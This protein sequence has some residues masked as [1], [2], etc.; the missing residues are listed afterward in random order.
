MPRVT[1]NAQTKRKSS[2]KKRRV[3]NT[4]RIKYGSTSA[5]SQKKQIMSN[6]V[7]IQRVKRMLPPPVW[8]DYQ[9]TG[10][11]QSLVIPGDDA[12]QLN[13]D[14]ISLMDPLNWTQVL[15]KDPTVLDKVSTKVL[16]I[17]LNLRYTLNFSER[18]QISLFVVTFRRNAANRNPA[19]LVDND[20]YIRDGQ[21]YNVR[22]N[23]AV[24]KVH[25]ARDVS[26]TSNAWE[27]PAAVVGASNFAG[28]PYSTF[29]KG[30]VNMKINTTIREPNGGT[31]KGMTN[32]QLPHWQRYY[33]LVFFYQKGS[34]LSVGESAYVSFDSLA[35]C[36]NTA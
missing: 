3:A 36:Y 22:L 15:R 24:F 11:L 28:N 27:Q 33:L 32:D 26:L 10:R 14:F 4:T 2:V 18:A 12:F 35:T 25:F 17:S 23:P 9:L 5:R 31:W 13:Y 7:T 6:A 19:V 30:Q 20:D 1:F 29:K 34:G 8:T 16:R 21:E